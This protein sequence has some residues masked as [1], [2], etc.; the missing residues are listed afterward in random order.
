MEDLNVLQLLTDQAGV[1]LLALVM[2]YIMKGWHENS[3][4]RSD[5]RAKELQQAHELS[6]QRLQSQSDEHKADKQVLAEIVRANTESNMKLI[7]VVER[8]ERM[9]Q[10]RVGYVVPKAGD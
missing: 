10:D 2:I 1:M 5:E 3:V 9:L 8:V 6:L 7:G 4:K